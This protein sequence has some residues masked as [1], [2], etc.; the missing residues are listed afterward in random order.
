MFSTVYGINE[1]KDSLKVNYM[2]IVELEKYFP[3]METR[4]LEK[5]GGGQNISL[6]KN[7]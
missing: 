4:D 6:E 7:V 3:F 1:G 2:N 5:L